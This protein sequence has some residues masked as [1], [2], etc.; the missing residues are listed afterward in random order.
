MKMDETLYSVFDASEDTHWWFLARRRIVLTM[1]ES[2]LPVGGR[3]RILDVG[4]GTGST[5]K[6]LEKLGPAVGADIS[7]DA[8]AYC[9]HRGCRDVRLV[10]ESELPFAEGEFD[11][12][13]SLD[14]LE[15]IED[16]EKAV[17]EYR[18]VLKEGGMLLITVP[19]YRWLWSTH[20]DINRHKRRYTRRSFKNL[21][22]GAGCP[23]RRLTYFCTY[24]FLPVAVVRFALKG[25][26]EYFHWQKK[27]LDFK[28]P[29][30]AVNR[31]CEAVFASEARWLVK[32]DFPFGSSLMAVC[33]KE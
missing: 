7:P 21:L 14:V 1:A 17:R 32:R 15:H 2:F 11:F 30:R 8:I 23:P 27:G 5:L 16:D 33:L 4:C 10:K 12:V 18:R 20:D 9:R 13:L 25:L 31:V 3:P 22:N 19:A 29:G 6:E 28:I 24:L 26:S